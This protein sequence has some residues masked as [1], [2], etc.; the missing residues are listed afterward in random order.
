M[1]EFPAPRPLLVSIVAWILVAQALVLPVIAFSTFGP[2]STGVF[3][4]DGQVYPVAEYGPMLAALML[5]WWLVAV[6]VSYGFLKGFGW[7]RWILLGAIVGQIIVLLAVDGF[8]MA[9]LVPIAF[10]VLVGWYLFGKDN[11]RSYFE[12]RRIPRR[13]DQE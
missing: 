3:R 1:S 8:S 6:A 5:G 4:F 12:S 7:S 13:D 2:G 11:V 9:S 10:T